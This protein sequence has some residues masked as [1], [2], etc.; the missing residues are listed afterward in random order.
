MKKWKTFV[1]LIVLG[2][3]FTEKGLAADDWGQKEQSGGVTHRHTMSH[4]HENTLIE[5]TLE[6]NNGYRFGNLCRY[7]CENT[8][9]AS[10]VAV[11]V[12]SVVW[13]GPGGCMYG[14]NGGTH[15][16]GRNIVNPWSSNYWPYYNGY[17]PY[18][19]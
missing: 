10:L 13:C 4:N 15:W 6:N 8:Y 11:C 12:L 3:A 2:F 7:V 5:Q 9:K 18:H 16:Y 19:R 14:D 17:P 1:A